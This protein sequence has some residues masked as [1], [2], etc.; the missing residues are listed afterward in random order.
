MVSAILN[1]QQKVDSPWPLQIY[2]HNHHLHEIIL[3][4][5]EMVWY[6]SAKMVHG[7]VKPLNGSSFENVFVHYMPKYELLIGII[8][9]F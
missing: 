8:G 2:D 3:Q 6:E 7:R 5:G 4:P 9:Y 1:I